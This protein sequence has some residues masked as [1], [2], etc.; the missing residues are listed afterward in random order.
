[1]PPQ[2]A[3]VHAPQSLEQALKVWRMREAQRQS[4]APFDLL[5]DR[6][7]REIAAQRPQSIEDLHNVDGIDGAWIDRFG[8]AVCSVVAQHA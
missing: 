2:A 1:V 5:H 4:T 7:I 3:P 6:T 8:E